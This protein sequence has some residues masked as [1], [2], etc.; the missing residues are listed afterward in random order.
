MKLIFKEEVIQFDTQ[1]TV[2]V[3]I[4]TINQLLDD[5]YYFSHLIID[6]KEV[7]DDPEQ[8]LQD[9]LNEIRELEIVAKTVKEF[10]NDLLLSAE[11]YIRRAKPEIDS[12]SDEF[13]Q[14]P[15]S[16]SWHKF[17]QLLEGIQWLNQVIQTIDTT[18]EKPKNWV[19]Y[20]EINSN[21]DLELK[22]MEEAIENS[23]SVLIADLIKYEILSIIESLGSE[24]QLTIDTEGYRHDLN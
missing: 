15:T 9:Y 24:I 21:F 11:E 20:L 10:I 13:Y 5:N 8:Y 1:P 23:D 6:D 4:N 17:A 3:I 7:L 14:N 19:N 2:E 12:L 16:E 18:K 22:N